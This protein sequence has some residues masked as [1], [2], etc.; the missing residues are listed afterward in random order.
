[1]RLVPIERG[2]KVVV[3]FSMPIWIKAPRGISN[4]S[5]WPSCGLPTTHR[6]VE[7]T[8][9]TES[10]EAKKTAQKTNFRVITRITEMLSLLLNRLGWENDMRIAEP[11]QIAMDRK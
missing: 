8:A 11:A 10:R 2:K 4:V 7:A 5:P 6:A 1:M 3:V 9:D